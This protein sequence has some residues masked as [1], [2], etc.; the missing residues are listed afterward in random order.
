MWY[1]GYAWM[2]MTFLYN[3]GRIVPLWNIAS[4]VND[5]CKRDWWLTHWGTENPKIW[6]HIADLKSFE[7]IGRWQYAGWHIFCYNSWCF[8]E[9]INE[10]QLCHDWTVFKYMTDVFGKISI[11]TPKC[12]D[13][14]KHLF[15]DEIRM[16]GAIYWLTH[17]EIEWL[18][19]RWDNGELAKESLLKFRLT[20]HFFFFRMDSDDLDFWM[21][22]WFLI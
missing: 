15:L 22:S 17:E 14:L 6:E 21:R 7:R 4:L 11:Q 18:K 9:G 8:E 12:K 20:Y 2:S 13:W 5:F 16:W 3:A 19:A 1:D 10:A